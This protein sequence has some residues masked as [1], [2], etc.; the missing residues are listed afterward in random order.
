MVERIVQSTSLP[1]S[2]DIEAGY[3]RDASQ[4]LANIE[5]LV[6]LGVVGINIEDSV[7]NAARELVDAESFAKLITLIKQ[8][9]SELAEY[10]AGERQTFDVALDPVGTDF[11]Q[12][13]WQVLL[14]IPCGE[15]RSYLAQARALDKPSAVRAVAIANGYNKISIMIPCL[16]VIGSDGS[17]TGYGGGLITM[18][19]KLN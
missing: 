3:S 7:V 13:V 12:N 10:F 2:V 6:A 14:D 16:R 9:K 19:E 15:T 18:T 11:Q 5:Q 4:V 1:L 17:L 8:A